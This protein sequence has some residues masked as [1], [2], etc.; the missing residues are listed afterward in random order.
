MGGGG[1]HSLT[2]LLEQHNKQWIHFFLF[3]LLLYCCDNPTSPLVF[4]SVSAVLYENAWEGERGFTFRRTNASSL[5]ALI[6][7]WS[8]LLIASTA[9]SSSS[10]YLSCVGGYFLFIRFTAINASFSWI[11]FQV[12]GFIVS[13][14]SS[15]S[16]SHNIWPE[17]TTHFGNQ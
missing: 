14:S 10:S 4:L 15:S 7:L 8:I 16:I 12:D 3:R 6:A 17:M 11:K 5:T 9:S 2:H 1:T 13:T